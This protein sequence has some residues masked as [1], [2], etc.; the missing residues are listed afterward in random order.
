MIFSK[1]TSSVA[2]LA[3]IST[4]SGSAVAA[5]FSHRVPV[6]HL[7]PATVVAPPSI[8]VSPVSIEFPDVTTGNFA[9][10]L[11]TV[12]NGSS[13]SA[14][15][16][17]RAL[18]SGPT[19]SLL[20]NTCGE[21]G[22]TVSVPASGS[23]SATIRFSPSAAQV[24]TGSLTIDSSNANPNLLS[25]AVLGTGVSPQAPIMTSNSSAI[26]ASATGP[27]ELSAIN[28]LVISNT[29]SANL[30]ISRLDL[31]TGTT[32]TSSI[33]GAGAGIS[34]TSTAPWTVSSPTCS[35][36]SSV[37]AVLPSGSCTYNVRFAP[38]LSSAAGTFS[39]NSIK[40]VSSS[41]PALADVEVSLTGITQGDPYYNSVVFLNRFNQFNVLVDDKGNAGTSSGVSYST[42]TVKTGSGSGAF[43]DSFN[44]YLAY[45]DS[46]R[47]TF[48]AG[49]FTL[50]TWVNH[51]T[52][53]TP[54]WSGG[55]QVT[56]IASQ[57]DGGSQ[58]SWNWTL[59]RNAT[60]GVLTSIFSGSATGADSATASVSASTSGAYAF[61]Q[62]HHLAI[63]RSAGVLY[64]FVDGQLINGSGSPF[65]VNLADV[66]A[67]LL[68]GT[69]MYG[70]VFQADARFQGHMDDFRI[71]KGIG[72]YTAPFTPPAYQPASS[73]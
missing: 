34:S 45:S 51:T 26:S 58:L 39:N 13:A 7:S 38:P 48:G 66:S 62:W 21:S 42:T 71:T 73:M 10:V 30:S 72:R 29:G 54:S 69:H 17:V 1:I 9:D 11:V 57:R 50:E 15:N 65:T 47:W 4:I 67:G 40:V 49:D 63:S 43:L 18:L 6:I 60:T 55:T 44:N 64:M 36:G 59:N 20:S 56:L 46:P 35:A 70:G 53:L 5:D 8:Q 24:Y 22:N 14:L 2:T 23:C 52:M 68:I 28:P 37:A 61:N 16:S 19:F 3:V 33:L 27:G 25:V 31:Y 12:S 32:L 41:T